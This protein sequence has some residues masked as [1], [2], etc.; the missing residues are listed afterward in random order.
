M[1]QQDITDV[2]SFCVCSLQLCNILFSDVYLSAMLWRSGV[3]CVAM[4]LVVAAS[5]SC[6]LRIHSSECLET[7]GVRLDF[8]E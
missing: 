2:F 3:A 7:V 5:L 4:V 8:V 6:V 1:K